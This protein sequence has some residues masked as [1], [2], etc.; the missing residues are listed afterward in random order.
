MEDEL[1]E[2]DR[3]RRVVSENRREEP[4][5]NELDVRTSIR[6]TYHLWLN[7]GL[8]VNRLNMSGL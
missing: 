7:F 4:K 3:Q 6:V 5:L 2:F 8:I 1:H